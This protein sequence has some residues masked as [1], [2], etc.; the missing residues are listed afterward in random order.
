MGWLEDQQA[1]EAAGGEPTDREGGPVTRRLHMH[2]WHRPVEVLGEDG[3]VTG[4]RFERT[5]L[6]GAG[7]A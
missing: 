3:K 7:C 1:R 2:F 4:M 5:R 6:D